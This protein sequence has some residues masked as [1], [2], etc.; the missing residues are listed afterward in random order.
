MFFQ[1]GLFRQ[2]Y[3]SFWSLYKQNSKEKRQIITVKCCLL[4]INTLYKGVA[5]EMYSLGQKVAD[6]FMKLSKIGFSMDFL[7]LFFLQ[8]FTKKCQ[9]LALGWMAVYS[10]SNPTI[11]GIFLKFPNFLRS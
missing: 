3:S 5:N 2:V 6:K 11:S 4:K 7:Q 8:I 9:N 10:P 1:Q